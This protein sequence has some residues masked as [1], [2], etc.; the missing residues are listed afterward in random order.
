[1]KKLEKLL[2]EL[3]EEQL[4]AAV[5]YVTTPKPHKRPVKHH[6]GK[7]HVRIGLCGDSHIGSLYA[8]Y[9]VLN[10]LFKRFKAEGVQAVYHTGDI[11][12]GY[13]RR[14]GHSLE[15]EL[16]GS[17][18]QVE[19]VVERFPNIG[20]P[21]YFIAGDHDMWHYE[22]AGTEIGKQI[23]KERKDMHYL[24]PFNAT[25]EIAP[26]CRLMLVHPAKGTAYAISYQIQ[27]M[28]EAFSGGEK[29]EILAV[30]HYHKI[31][32]LN[33]RNVLAFQTGT[34]EDQ[35]PWMRR[36]NLS[37]HLGGWVLDIWLKPNGYPDKVEMK[38]FPYDSGGKL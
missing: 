19:G 3:P 20:V 32:F 10:D 24:G 11:T 2:Q 18:A 29:P 7:R 9:D 35:T 33:Y 12:E 36:M 34:T 27:K 16:H 22:N 1:M 14:K 23:E 8:N 31:E 25:I 6:W 4:Q 37:A 21:I 26:K 13:N 5:D 17:D 30:G 28:I 38:L 15:C